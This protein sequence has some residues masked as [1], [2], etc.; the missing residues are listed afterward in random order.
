MVLAGI[1]LNV[2]QAIKTT[3]VGGLEAGVNG[4]LLAKGKKNTI[5]KRWLLIFS[6]TLDSTTSRPEQDSCQTSR[7]ANAL[8]TYL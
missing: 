4:V 6:C 1:S 3:V 2:L 7:P 5:F 8:G